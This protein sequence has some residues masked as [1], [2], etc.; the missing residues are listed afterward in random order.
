MFAFL[1]AHR[2]EL[3]LKEMFA[4]LFRPVVARRCR[5]R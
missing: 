2:R 4:D 5:P 1:A 3:F